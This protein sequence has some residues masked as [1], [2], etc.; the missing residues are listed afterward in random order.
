[1]NY[2]NRVF[3]LGGTGFVGQHLLNRLSR[4]GIRSRVATAHPHRFRALRLIPNCEIVELRDWSHE[5]LARSMEGCDAL[6]N[7]VGILNPGSGRSFEASHV[8][9]VEH[10]T[11][12]A[13]DAGVGRFLQMSAL[14]ADAEKGPSE[15]LRTKGRGE[16]MAHAAAARGLAVTSFRPS[17]IFGRG[18][19]FFNRFARLLHLL[20]GPFPLA[21]A[22]SRFAPVYVGDVIEAMVKS[23]DDSATHGKAYELCGPRVFSLRDL[24]VYTGEQ[25]GRP[26]RVIPLSD[27][28][29]QLQA[30]VFQFLP[31][32][33]FTMDNY[34]S[35]QVDSVCRTQGLAELGLTATDIDA[36]VPGYLK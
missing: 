29:A 16:A 7:L 12:A 14:N 17:V 35:L 27:R 9:L 28:A 25:I 20:P 22:E 32:K 15:Y 34:L 24:V 33:P 10:A 18:D 5:G 13:L 2:K 1:M 30:K 31:G 21:C 11:Q 23:L 26:V 3:V 8:R 19:S 36:V 6:I 4:A